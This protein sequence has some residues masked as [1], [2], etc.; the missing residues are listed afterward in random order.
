M[1]NILRGTPHLALR[2]SFDNQYSGRSIIHPCRDVL[3]LFCLFVL[4]F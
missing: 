4:V 2:F 3:T 1:I